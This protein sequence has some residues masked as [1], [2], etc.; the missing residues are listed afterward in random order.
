MAKADDQD[1]IKTTTETVDNMLQNIENASAILIYTCIARSMALGGEHFKEMELINQKL[2]GKLP[3]LMANSGGEICPTL[4]SDK[5]AI[6][7]FHNNAFIAV[8]F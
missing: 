3:F 5:K 2:G 4:V 7:R 1:V 6:N 8:M